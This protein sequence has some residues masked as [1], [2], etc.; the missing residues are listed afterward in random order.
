MNVK[1]IKELYQNINDLSGDRLNILKTA[2]ESF[3]ETRAAESAASLA[4]YALFSLFPLLLLFIALGSYF[5]GSAQIYETVT[6]L[7]QQAI[8]ISTRVINENLR[9]VL[10][11]RE[12][13]GLIGLV[14]LLWAAS[15]VFTNLAYNINLAWPRAR[16][17]TFLQRR[18]MGVRIIGGLSG[19]L[20]L[21]IIVDWLSNLLSFVWI[22]NVPFY[23]L[24]LWRLLSTIASWLTVFLLFFA[25]YRWVP[26]TFVRW[27]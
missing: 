27:R 23:D 15:G 17:R 6:E 12:T 2:L 3:S 5:L 18:L 20:I 24:S 14:T 19:L 21:A 16:R 11:A 10:E 22:A 8:P 4:Y 9:E 1:H 13:V 7:A 26:T 25:L